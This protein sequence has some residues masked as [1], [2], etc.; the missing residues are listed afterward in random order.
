MGRRKINTDP[1]YEVRRY[2][3]S[4]PPADTQVIEW[5]N[6]QE[7]SSHSVR[8]LIK[9]YLE[10]Y[11]MMDPLC[12]PL[13]ALR[14]IFGA[15]DSGNQENIAAK[16]AAQNAFAPQPVTQNIQTQSAATSAVPVTPVTQNIQTQP[17]TV[18]V[19]PVMQTIQQETVPDKITPETSAS[20]SEETDVFTGNNNDDNNDSITATMSSSMLDSLMG[21]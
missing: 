11:G 20:D 6:S 13:S 7:N 3:I 14:T 18:P 1:A 5:M 17:V 21:I 19:T 16:T 12:L 15:P 8:I 2:H 9:A 10:K 4:V